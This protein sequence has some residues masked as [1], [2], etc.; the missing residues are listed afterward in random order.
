VN[1]LVP[2]GLTVLEVAD[3]NGD[4][5]PDLIAG[6]IPALSI[7]L[8]SVYLVNGDGTF[9]HSGNYDPGISVGSLVIGDFDDDHHVDLAAGGVDYAFVN[10]LRGNGMALST[11]LGLYDWRR[12]WCFSG[13]G[14]QS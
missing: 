11:L 14:F 13:S 2:Q 7:G 5:K 10:I 9:T 12:T 8:V 6:S 4:N 1:Y 3:I